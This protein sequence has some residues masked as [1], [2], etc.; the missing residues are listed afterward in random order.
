MTQLIDTKEL[1]INED[2]VEISERDTPIDLNLIDRAMFSKNKNTAIG[3]KIIS[4]KNGGMLTIEPPDGGSVP[5]SF[6]E[7]IFL[8]LLNILYSQS[9]INGKPSRTIYTTYTEIADVLGVNK[10]YYKSTRF[11]ASLEKLAK[12]SY[13]FENSFLQRDIPN[14]DKTKGNITDY[15]VKSLSIKSV[16]RLIDFTEI[17]ITEFD[18]Q[19]ELREN[20]NINTTDYEVL[21]RL[22]SGKVSSQTSYFLRIDL[23]NFIYENL[24][25]KVYLKHSLYHLLNIKDKIARGIYMYLDSKQGKEVK[26]SGSYSPLL[27]KSLCIVTGETLA[28]QGSVTWE[29]KRVSS[30]IL[31]INR[32][33]DYLVDNGYIKSYEMFKEKPLSFS[34]YKVYFHE[35]QNRSS[36]YYNY[37]TRRVGNAPEPKALGLKVNYNFTDKIQK[38]IDKLPELNN[39]SRRILYEI[40][41]PLKDEPVEY[42]EKIL[43]LTLGEIKVLAILEKIIKRKSANPPLTSV[44]G[45][46]ITVATKEYYEEELHQLKVDEYNRLYG[47]TVTP[48]QESINASMQI[49]QKDEE[50]EERIR[51]L[52][53]NLSDDIKEKYFNKAAK[54]AEKL[55]LFTQT[56]IA[57]HIYAYKEL[58]DKYK[59]GI[60]LMAGNLD[61]YS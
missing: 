19:R 23:S 59:P 48:F 49:K 12:T 9:K 26:E 37:S 38:A 20:P 32:A 30:S 50:H 58:N 47:S 56:D 14:I 29:S 42:N 61:I 27:N 55:K 10:E 8:V 18:I 39:E 45:Y 44:N 43:T 36:E 35:Y 41:T 1:I 15:K 24:L 40:F 57:I 2:L 13:T 21:E 53:E 46:F 52:W 28:E 31:I 25:N 5:T 54:Y 22:I 11:R 17:K 3:K 34:W 7:D 16:F 60:R 51:R 33:L 4:F 6:E